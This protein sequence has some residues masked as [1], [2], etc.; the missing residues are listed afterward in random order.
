MG[1]IRGQPVAGADWPNVATPREDHMAKKRVNKKSRPVLVTTAH[2]GV[3]FGYLDGDTGKLPG[4][5]RLTNARNCLYW[6][7]SLHGV[8]G[9]ASAGPSTGCRIGPQVDLTLYNVT[10]VTEVTVEAAKRWEDAPWT[11]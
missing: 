7:R 10:S 6:D 9:L 8:F 5:I 1:P 4:E 11:N 2:R 3:F